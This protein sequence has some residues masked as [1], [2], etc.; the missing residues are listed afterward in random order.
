[1]SP[2]MTGAYSLRRRLLALALGVVCLGWAVVAGLAFSSAHREA[3]RMFD[4]QLRLVADTLA[5]IVAGGEAGHVAH[6]LE[7]HAD[8]YDLP[9]IYQVWRMG[10][11]RG[12]AG[13]VVR[14]PR[15]PETPLADR[16]G[17]SEREYRQSTWRFFAREHEGY[18]VIVGHDHAERYRVAAALALNLAWP[19]LVGL[20][21]MGLALWWGVGRALAPV[22]RV[23]REVAGLEPERLRRVGADAELPEEVAPL[24]AA[25]NGLTERVALVLDKERRFTAD[26]AHELRTPLAALKV[27]AQVAQ[28]AQGGEARERALEQVLA[29]VERMSYLVE[30]LLTLARLDPEA[31][32]ESFAP[33][34]LAALA[35]GVC[36]ELAPAALARRQTLELE[37]GPGV[38]WG[39][40]GW[41]EILLRNLVGN[42]VRHTPAGSRIVVSIGS[43]PGQ[44]RL[45]VRDDG[46]GI[47]AGEREALLG[48]FAR[49]TDASE[50]G[51]G[52]GLSIVARIAEAHG[53]RVELGPGLGGAG[54]GV[55]VTLP[56]QSL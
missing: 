37:P 52:L 50:D 17:F 10:A 48:R 51:C 22:G 53:G 23:A 25:L 32:R 45:L 4:A 46:P 55:A 30:Q 11:E 20:P 28:R 5:A 26:A 13:L 7:E 21:L 19:I 9:V 3:D 18:R 40:R 14:S 1:M 27:Q 29:G 6:E 33:V 38:A 8:R 49:G 39:N 56:A 12:E 36:A 16:P 54:L 44:V 2:A 35:E 43:A 31:G 41:L 15:A 34:E 24:V 47:P 42:A